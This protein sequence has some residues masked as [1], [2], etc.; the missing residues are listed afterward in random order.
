MG[1]CL[2]SLKEGGMLAFVFKKSRGACLRWLKKRGSMLALVVRKTKGACLR[3]FLSRAS[4]TH[5]F[6]VRVSR[7]HFARVFRARQEHKQT[8]FRYP[9]IFAKPSLSAT[10]QVSRQA[11]MQACKRAYKHVTT[12]TCKHANMPACKQHASMQACKHA[13]KLASMCAGARA[14]Q[15][16]S[17]LG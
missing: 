6:R 10:R 1:A 11:S 7:A 9:P 2:R 5:A 14:R 12:Q 17:K 4:C 8:M 3:S 13:C 15:S 16:A